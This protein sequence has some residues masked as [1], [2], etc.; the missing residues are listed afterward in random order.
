MAKFKT[1]PTIID[2]YQFGGEELP[3][4]AW[5]EKYGFEAFE[6]PRERGKLLGRWPLDPTISHADREFVYVNA[7]DWMVEID[8]IL[9]SLADEYFRDKFEPVTN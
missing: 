9:H 7:G 8:G 3:P 2:A 4:D 1:K 5:K 6:S